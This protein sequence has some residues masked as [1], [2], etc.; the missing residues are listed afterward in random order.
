ME[1]RSAPAGDSAPHGWD[2]ET[3]E[4]GVFWREMGV[5]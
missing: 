2:L 4:V 1:E 5:G 3:G